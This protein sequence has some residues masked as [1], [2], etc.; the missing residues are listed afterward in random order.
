MY[1][2]KEQPVESRTPEVPTSAENGDASSQGGT[3][4]AT[5]VESKEEEKGGEARGRTR[6]GRKDGVTLVKR[7]PISVETIAQ[8]LA[9]EISNAQKL[10]KLHKSRR[11]KNSDELGEFRKL[12]FELRP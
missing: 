1:H 10:I 9:F 12:I 7:K 4:M 3:E 5:T 6:G 2:P 11:K 8:H